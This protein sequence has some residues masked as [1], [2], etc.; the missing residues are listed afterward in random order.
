MLF[1]SVV[2]LILVLWNPIC[3][4]F[5]IRH[6]HRYSYYKLAEA[7]SK[8]T[9]KPL[10][11]LGDPNSGYIAT[12]NMPIMYGCGDVCT[13]LTG[14]PGCPVSTQ[15]IKGD[16]LEVLSKM[17]TNSH[18]IYTSYTIEYIEDIEP[19]ITELKRVSGGDLYVVGSGIF[20]W[21]YSDFEGWMD[22]KHMVV[23]APPSNPNFIIWSKK[24]Y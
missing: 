2:A 18:V 15:K 20:S 19:V 10:L 14:C 17:K 6:Y 11:V 9:G 7:A 3:R 24:K 8:R 21:N 1:R 22:Q 23:D 4:C 16:A 13:D 5:L 12:R